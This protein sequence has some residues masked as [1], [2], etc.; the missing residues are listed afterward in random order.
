L[1]WFNSN[2]TYRKSITLSRASGTVTN[3]QMKLLVGE[4]AGATGEDVDCGGH[5]L[6]S[7]DDLRFTAADGITLLDYW[8]E[9]ISG[10]T[11]NQLA[12]VWIEFDSIG[13]GATTFYMYYGNSG[14]MPYSNISDTFLFGDD[15]EGW[16][17]QLISA[18]SA[19]GVLAQNASGDIICVYQVPSTGALAQRTST[20]GGLTWS[21]ATTI[22]AAGTYGWPHLYAIGDTIFLSYAK[23]NG[24]Y[25]DIK[26]RKSI[27]GGANWGAEVAVVATRFA[28]SDI[29][30]LDTSNVLIATINSAQTGIDIYK[31]TDG[32]SNWASYSTPLSGA[33]NKQEDV[34]IEKLSNGDVLLQWE[35]EVAEL[36]KS[37]LKSKR[38]TDGGLNWSS[39]ITIWNAEDATY[40]YEGSGFFYDNNGDLI[41][42]AYTNVDSV[43]ANC[44]YENYKL[45]YKKST[46]QGVTWGASADLIPDTR[47]LGPEGGFIKLA[48]NHILLAHT[49]FWMGATPNGYVSR[50]YHDLTYPDIATAS[51]KWLT[52]N[53][54][55]FV[56][57]DGSAKI[58]RVEGYVTGT[59]AYR[60]H[61]PSAYTGADYAIR[62]KVKG[63]TT[64]LRFDFRYTDVD[65]HYIFSLA[66]TEAAIYKD[67]AGTYT[68]INS[69][70][71][72]TVADTWYIIDL[73]LVG[74]AIKSYVDGV[75]KN[76]FTDATYGSGYA[77]L[78]SGNNLSTNGPVFFDWFLVRQY[79]A[80]EPAWG[81]WGS[82]EEVVLRHVGSLISKKS[83]FPIPK[84]KEV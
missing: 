36:G 20:D 60:G 43:L 66:A 55:L 84:M 42:G 47:G 18:D 13:T 49:S 69:V 40:D 83:I 33:S 79:L 27:D 21:S 82:E 70:A 64:N 4:S 35:E 75:L 44:Q 23:V 24:D 78:G 46:N 51:S 74:T 45:K 80:T 59:V 48:D 1:A 52:G 62:V 12:T 5:V 38:S 57:K 7:F 17:P 31:S 68:S 14:A 26:F 15:F 32:G 10:T 77:G 72:T 56:Q 30:G 54:K 9:S 73:L 16:F 65:N 25:W 3:Y 50:I 19:G 41:S 2:W 71:F 29:L 76:N 37:Y 67:V 39:V 34:F 22:V 6:P 53:G 28:D 58:A 11:P 8:I 61:I 63:G 81:S